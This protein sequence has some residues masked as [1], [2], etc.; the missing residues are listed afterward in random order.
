MSYMGPIAYTARDSAEAKWLSTMRDVEKQVKSCKK[1]LGLRVDDDYDDDYHD[2]ED[3]DN[4]GQKELEGPSE[5]EKRDWSFAEKIPMT[6][7][8]LP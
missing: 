2:D 1:I 8:L 7:R 4:D 5:E 3:D 6:N